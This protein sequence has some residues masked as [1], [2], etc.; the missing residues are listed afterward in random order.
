MIEQRLLCDS[1]NSFKGVF[2][3]EE[4]N[5]QNSSYISFHKVC[6]IE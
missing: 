3:L 1:F 4:F 5:D 6:V 2:V